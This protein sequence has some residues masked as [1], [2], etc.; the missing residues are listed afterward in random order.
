MAYLTHPAMP[1][2]GIRLALLAAAATATGCPAS[3]SQLLAEKQEV[4][5]QAALQQGRLDLNCQE[6]TAS[7][8]SSA[9]ILSQVWGDWV[10]RINRLKY[11]IGVTGCNQRTTYVVSCREGAPTCFTPSPEGRPQR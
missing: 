7:V 10:V 1:R 9:H 6:A 8:L 3:Q 11:T 5:M 2:A 4:A